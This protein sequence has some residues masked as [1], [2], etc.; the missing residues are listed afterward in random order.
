MTCSGLIMF[1]ILFH[2]LHGVRQIADRVVVFAWLAA[3][4]LAAAWLTVP[5]SIAVGGMHW[6]GTWLDVLQ[7]A[8]TDRWCIGA[9][10]VPGYI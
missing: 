5:S 1:N 3:A 10:A 2:Y 8:A 4:W 7:T 6:Q 9:A